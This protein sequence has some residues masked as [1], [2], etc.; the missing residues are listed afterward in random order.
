MKQE[1]PVFDVNQIMEGLR[2][3]QPLMGENGILMPLIKQ[4]SE[5]MLKAELETHL[6]TEQTP[7]RKNGYTAKTIKTTGGSFEL[8][9]PRDRANTFEPQLIKKN[10]TSLTNEVETKVLSLFGLGMSYLDIAK[11]VADM[12]GLEVSNATI[13]TIT[14]KIIP[15]LEQWRQRPLDPLYPFV[16]MDAIHY[17]IREDGRMSSRAIYT[18]LALNVEG[19]KEI[20]GLY[21]SATEGAHFWL[22][23]LTDLQ[24]RGVMDI[25]IASV[26][27]LKGFPDAINTIFPKT[28]V[29]LCVVHQIRNSLKYVASKHQKAFMLDLKTVYQADT[30]A[31]AENALNGLEE[32]W[33]QQYAVVIKSWRNNWENLATYFRFPEAIR[34]AIYTT[35]AVEAVH[36]QFRKLTKTKGAF[37]NENAL[38]KLLYIGIKNASEKWTMPIHNWALTLSQLAI[39]FEGRVN[40]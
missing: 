1:Q 26:D 39:Y 12:Y 20:L 28:E 25:L 35:N 29:Q 38:L 17:K 14:D 34:R 30:R 2:T 31:A 3:R 10:Q 21:T 33:G 16:W 23:V 18:V 27:G 8:N 5:A 11:H 19:K 15:E 24:Q 7:N 40:I 37:A 36:R 32:K 22:S 13:S 4:L 6:E 9:T